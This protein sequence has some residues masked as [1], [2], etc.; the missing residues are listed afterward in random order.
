MKKENLKLKEGDI[1][2]INS[3]DNH[4]L[5]RVVFCERLRKL[6]LQNK[7]ENGIFDNNVRGNKNLSTFSILP[8]YKIRIVGFKKTKNQSTTTD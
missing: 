4:N 7:E 8:N 3:N 1:V 2:T 5:K 6:S